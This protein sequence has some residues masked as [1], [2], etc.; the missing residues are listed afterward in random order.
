MYLFLGLGSKF[1]VEMAAHLVR[2]LGKQLFLV[3]HLP[4]LPPARSVVVPHA[5]PERD[6]EFA[7]G[8][9]LVLV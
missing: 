3:V 1:G 4:A 9:M 6:R 2:E 5:P 7:C 8:F